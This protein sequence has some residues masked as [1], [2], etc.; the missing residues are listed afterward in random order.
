MVKKTHKTLHMPASEDCFI[1]TL[2]HYGYMLKKPDEYSQLFIEHASKSSGFVLD[3][4]AAYGVSTIPALK[5]GAYVIANDLDERHLDILWQRTPIQDR[6]RL[7]LKPGKF[8]YEVNFPPDTLDGILAS[9]VLH[10]LSVDELEEAMRVIYKLLKTNGKF[11][12]FTSTPHI[13]LFKDFLPV[14]QERKQA[15][16]KWP[17][18]ITNCWVYAP[19]RKNFIPK[20]IH[21]LDEDILEPF[22]LSLGFQIEQKSYVSMIGYAPDIHTN[23][24]EYIGFVLKK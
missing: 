15:Q 18:Y 4:G 20:K 13:G 6:S 8:P 17:G 5:G 19:N 1:P 21:L 11:F 2:N 23:G 22:F 12:F 24:K 16:I 3:I 10:Y 14:Y 7:L 9:G